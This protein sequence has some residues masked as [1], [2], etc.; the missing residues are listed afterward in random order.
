MFLL[1]LTTK[2]KILFAKMTKLHL[3]TLPQET[4]RLTHGT[5]AQMQLQQRLPEKDLTIVFILLEEQKQLN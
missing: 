5:L 2:S 1:S 4:F 3:Q